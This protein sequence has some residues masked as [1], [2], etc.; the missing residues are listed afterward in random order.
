MLLVWMFSGLFG[1]RQP[2]GVLFPGEGHPSRCFP[3]LLI[4]SCVG[5]R[6]RG[7]SSSTLAYLLVSSLFISRLC[8]HSQCSV[9]SG[10][11][12]ASLHC[13]LWFQEQLADKAVK[14]HCS[15]HLTY[16]TES[17]CETLS[18]RCVRSLNFGSLAE[19][20]QKS[21]RPGTAWR[22]LL[23]IVAFLL[24]HIFNIV[25]TPRIVNI[26][27][28]NHLIRRYRVLVWNHMGWSIQYSS[29]PCQALYCCQFNGG[30]NDVRGSCRVDIS[31]RVE[32]TGSN[33]TFRA[34]EMAL[35]SRVGKGRGLIQQS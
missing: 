29:A 30:H 12:E 35:E 24:V 15:D 27:S 6:H 2:F 21:E 7:L 1:T 20:G 3:Q 23:D 26:Y 32:N 8:S 18:E 34:G 31:G 17:D 16:A 9:L 25:F 19:C 33:C 10:S 22:F 5:L 11:A 28:A 14:R 4:V 13:P